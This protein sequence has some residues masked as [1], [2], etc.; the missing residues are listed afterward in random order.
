MGY[1]VV[2]IGAGPGGYKC[3]IKAAELGL[4]VACVDKNLL[5]GGTCL[6]VGCIPSKALLDYS[7]KYYAA[8]N[9]FGD[10]GITVGDVKFDLRKMFAARDKEVSTLSSGIEGL[11]SYVGVECLRGTASVV[12]EIGGGFEISVLHEGGT[13]STVST[14]KVVLATGSSP[15]FLPGIDVDEVGVVSSDGALSMSVPKELLVIGGGAIGLEMSSIWARLGSKVTVVECASCIASGFDCEVSSALLGCLKK[16]GIDFMLSHRVVSVS[17]RGAKL[18][19]DCEALSDGGVT[20]MEVDRA[21]VAVGRKP[22]VGGVVA[23]DGLKLDDRG[24]ILVDGRYETSIAGIFAIG[25]VIG[26]LMLAHKAEMEGHAVA[27]VISGVVS[28]VDYGVVPA[29]IYTHPAAASVGRSE[30]YLKS[31]GYPYRVGKSSFAANGR[32]RVTG[33]KEGFVKVVVC[34][35]TDTILGAH[36]IGAYADTMINEAAVA[37]GYRASSKDICHI[38]HSHPDVNEAFRDACEAAAVKGK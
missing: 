3:A 15:F 20:S 33:D 24:F 32:A 34:R 13:A 38:C 4:K 5:L 2:V 35:D 29:V 22:N 12:R 23:I 26:G 10:F 11:F 19:V 27:E 18:V 9:L 36:I 16:Q 37:L 28:K 1:D 17:K 25:D 30:E 8:K 14:K 21:L 31:V 6:R 7:Y